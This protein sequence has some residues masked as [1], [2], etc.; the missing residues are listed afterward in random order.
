MRGDFLAVPQEKSVMDDY[1]RVLVLKNLES[2]FS[3][4]PIDFL[5]YHRRLEKYENNNWQ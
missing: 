1:V 5:N 2:A 4:T 3:E